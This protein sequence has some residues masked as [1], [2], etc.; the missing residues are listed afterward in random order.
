VT[1]VR[2]TPKD[3]LVELAQRTAGLD[4]ELRAIRRAYRHRELGPREQR[5]DEL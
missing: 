4:P 2:L 3:L 5:F 1:R